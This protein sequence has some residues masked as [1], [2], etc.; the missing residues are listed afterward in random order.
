M[1]GLD[2]N[3][4]HWRMAINIFI[5][6]SKAENT[7]DYTIISSP[8]NFDCIFFFFF[9]QEHPASVTLTC[10]DWVNKYCFIHSQVICPVNLSRSLILHNGVIVEE[11]EESSF[12][13][14]LCNMNT[15]FRSLWILLFYYLY[16]CVTSLLLMIHLC[17]PFWKISV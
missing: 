13:C 1:L 5:S 7:C 14:C 17:C 16:F 11:E 2:V 15:I 10:C 12:Y 3:F 6:A 9:P 8:I 4:L